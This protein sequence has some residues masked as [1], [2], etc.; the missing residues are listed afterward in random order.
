VGLDLRITIRCG[1]LRFPFRAKPK[2]DALLPDEAGDV[3][4]TAPI[5]LFTMLDRK[6]DRASGRHLL[7]PIY[8]SKTIT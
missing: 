8:H 2:L 4:V 5:R 1:S 7:T 3:P 6:E